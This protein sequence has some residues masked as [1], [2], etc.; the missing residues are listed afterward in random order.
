MVWAGQWAG[1]LPMAPS[2][3][4]AVLILSGALFS[5]A[6]WPDRRL[7][8]SGTLIAVSLVASLSLLV[9]VQFLTSTD[10]GM[11]RALAG[12]TQKLGL[13]P[14]GRMSPLTALVL[15]LESTALAQVLRAPR[16]PHAATVAAGLAGISTIISMAILA[17]YAYGSPLLYGGTVIPM[18]LPTALALLS[19]GAGQIWMAL[20]VSVELRAWSGSSLRGRLLR[21]FLPAT[22]LFIIFEGWMDVVLARR[23]AVNPA[24]WHSLT[25]LGGCVLM[26]GGHRLDRP[27]PRRRI[28]ANGRDAAPQREEIPGSL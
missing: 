22:V 23:T 28:G 5:A 3:A 4:L 8:R 10:T 12:T 20:P 13:T 18:A 21:A 27:A 16:R 14:V 7:S 25:A 1:F 2:T 19:V 24:L 17:G 26:V 11:E 6:R 9:L 15:L